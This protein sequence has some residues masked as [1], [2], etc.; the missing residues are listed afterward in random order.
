MLKGAVGA[1][2]VGDH[3]AV[4]DYLCEC[5]RAAQLTGDRNSYFGSPVKDVD[6]PTCHSPGV[7]GY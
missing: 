2:S 3:V 4:R 5:D 7:A 1:A 6:P